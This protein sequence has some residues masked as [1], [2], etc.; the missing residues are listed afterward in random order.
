MV[1]V[2]VDGFFSSMIVTPVL[3]AG[4]PVVVVVFEAGLFNL[5][6]L[7]M[8]LFNAPLPLGTTPSILG[9]AISNLFFPPALFN[10]SEFPATFLTSTS[11]TLIVLVL[12]T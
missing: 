9:W 1:K 2:G 5:T 6:K 4:V 3:L 12:Y 7:E 11:T 8:I 10:P